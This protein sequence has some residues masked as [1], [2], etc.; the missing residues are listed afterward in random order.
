[1]APNRQLEDKKKQYQWST[2]D[3][4]PPH[5]NLVPQIDS[6]TRAE[7]FQQN[8]TGE[9]EFSVLFRAI[10]KKK[11]NIAA[12]LFDFVR[13]GPSNV[14]KFSAS[15]DFIEIMKKHEETRKG[16]SSKPSVGDLNDAEMAWY[17]DAMFAQQNFTG[18]NP[19]TIQLAE[20]W[21]SKFRG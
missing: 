10:I 18:T 20:K 6:V 16:S 7:L 3:G 11:S 21:I 9:A 13:P 14:A 17:S 8:A 15:S 2:A 1:M 12:A 4:Y 19:T 5:L